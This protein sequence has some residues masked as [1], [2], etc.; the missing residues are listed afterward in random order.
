MPAQCV[1][2]HERGIVC[3]GFAQP[4][5][6]IGGL[7]KCFDLRHTAHIFHG[8]AVHV[9]LSGLETVHFFL[10]FSVEACKLHNKGQ[11][12]TDHANHSIPP[13]NP[14]KN[15]DQ[16]KRCDQ[17][18]DKIREL[19]SNKFL[20]AFNVFVHDFSQFA[21]SQGQMIPKRN[22]HNVVGIGHLQFIKRSKRCNVGTQ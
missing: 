3:N 15:N 6:G 5:K 1:F 20:N 14:K 4:L 18:G 19:V 7:I 12:N 16:N 11:N 21:A 9:F 8:G 13:V 10:G 22:M 17:R 2:Q